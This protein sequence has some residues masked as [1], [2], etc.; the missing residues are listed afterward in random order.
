MGASGWDYSV[1]YQGDLGAAFAGLRRRVF[2][3]HDYYWLGEDEGEPWPST[4]EEL[5]EDE[6]VQEEGTHSIL[7]IFRLI[8]PDEAEDCNT[9]RLVTDE[10]AFRLFGTRKPT[11]ADV[12]ELIDLPCQRWRGRC[13]VLHDDR[14]M[15]QEIYFWGASGD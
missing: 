8:G 9:L 6:D 7:D 10:E 1:P 3:G 5:W 13:A 2:D 11:R 12:P 14:G 15:P 4:E